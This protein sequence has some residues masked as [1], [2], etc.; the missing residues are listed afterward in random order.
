MHTK[1]KPLF[2]FYIYQCFLSRSSFFSGDSCS[3]EIG[4]RYKIKR[5]NK[6]ALYSSVENIWR[7]TAILSCTDIVPSDTVVITLA[8]NKRIFSWS[9]SG[10][11]IDPQASFE[12]CLSLNKWKKWLLHQMELDPN[13]PNGALTGCSTQ[14]RTNKKCK[15]AMVGYSL[16]PKVC[17]QAS[18]F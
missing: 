1:V 8:I 12:G 14:E 5:Q 15:S 4:K 2:C 3:S 17:G 10:L 13:H 9:I 6:Q 16:Q 11:L 7:H 18:L